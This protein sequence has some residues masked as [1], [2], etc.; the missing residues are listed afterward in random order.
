MNIKEL[1]EKIKEN[2]AKVMYGCDEAVEL[3][4]MSI[5]VS[6]HIL[7]E[8]VPGVGK[9]MLARSLAKSMVADFRRIQ[10][11]PDL[12]PSD[13]IGIN[14]FNQQE[15]KFQ[16]KRGPLFSQIVLADEINRAAPRTQSSLLEAMAEFQITV[17]GQTYPL[18][19]PFLVIAT[20]NP[21]ENAGTFPLPEAQLDRFM[22][23]MSLGYPDREEEK[24]LILKHGSYNPIDSLEAVVD[25][26]EIPKLSAELESIFVSEAVL[27]YMMDIVEATRKSDRITLGVSPRGAIGLY[28][29]SRAYACLK[30]RSYVLP[31]DVKYLVPY[32]LTHRI[33]IRGQGYTSEST[34]R[35]E[36]DHIVDSIAV[37]VESFREK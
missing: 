37:P 11:T 6:G 4:L 3:M 20:Q 7:L 14:Y 31:D 24:S 5:L 33:I 26:H 32:V 18:D 8:D 36:L 27:N 28:K 34:A 15:S 10:F 23:K 1:N 12:L 13:L 17:D 9:T 29:C 35:K 16:F 19:E 25:C 30:G 21:V 22:I 2:V